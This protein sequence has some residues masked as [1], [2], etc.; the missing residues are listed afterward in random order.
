MPLFQM[1]R[2]ITFE[3][4]EILKKDPQ[5][6]DSESENGGILSRKKLVLKCRPILDPSLM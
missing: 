4:N 1:R 3:Q 2:T 5:I 6:K